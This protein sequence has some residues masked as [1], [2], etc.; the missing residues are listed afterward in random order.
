MIVLGNADHVVIVRII[1]KLTVTKYGLLVQ[2]V[3][4]QAFGFIGISLIDSFDDSKITQG[5]IEVSLEFLLF[6]LSL[7]FALTLFEFLLFRY[8]HVTLKLTTHVRC[9]LVCK[10]LISPI[11]VLISLLISA[12]F[13]LGC[14]DLSFV[15]VLSK[16]TGGNQGCIPCRIQTMSKRHTQA[17]NCA[18]ILYSLLLWLNVAIQSC[19]D[20]GLLALNKIRIIY[21]VGICS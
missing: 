20:C 3:I 11:A 8:H 7:E 19:H 5:F 21:E 14:T 10:A 4:L 13:L 15:C 18:G 1:L 6:Y 9:E 12:H 16:R 17:F 2:P